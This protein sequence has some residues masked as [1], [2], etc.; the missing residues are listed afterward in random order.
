MYPIHWTVL[1]GHEACL[2]VLLD[3]GADIDSLNA[4]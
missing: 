3:K 1:R 2:R 4:G